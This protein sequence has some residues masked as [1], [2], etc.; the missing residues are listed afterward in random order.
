VLDFVTEPWPTFTRD[1]FGSPW[2]DSLTERA[3]NGRP[4]RE[5]CSRISSYGTRIEDHTLIFNNEKRYLL[6]G[7]TR[8]DEMERDVI[9]D[10]DPTASST[11][12]KLDRAVALVLEDA[13][14]RYWARRGTWI[15]AVFECVDR[16]QPVTDELLAEAC[17]YG[18]DA[19]QVER[20]VANW[21]ALF[22]CHGLE[23]LA[24][25]IPV[26]VDDF[27]A[28]GT[29]DRLIRTTRPLVFDTIVVPADTVCVLDLKSSLLRLA[30]GSPRFWMTYCIQVGL[31]S[32][33]R[34]YAVSTVGRDR[35]LDWPWEVDTRH[36]L[37]AHINFE[38]LEG[39]VGA[40]HLWHVD[41]DAGIEGAVL[42]RAARAFS[43]RRDL[44]MPAS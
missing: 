18:F 27:A 43:A 30:H 36:G 41:I 1:A 38:P 28:A 34:P 21:Q 35:R 32:L 39:R 24:I 40:V 26:V 31:Y 6:L 33:G 11:I 13:G 10:F 14:A 7:A 37:I 25:E 8:L 44:F 22:S 20:F 4:Q 16:G 3:V 29:L 5:R 17:V 23:M 9:N 2:I 12:G 42:A 15:H 19:G